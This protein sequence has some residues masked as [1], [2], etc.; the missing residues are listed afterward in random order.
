MR[1]FK[2]KTL[3]RIARSVTNM[4]HPDEVKGYKYQHPSIQRHERTFTDLKGEE[5]I[6]YV[7]GT[8]VRADTE[9]QLYQHMKRDLR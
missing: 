4:K 9:R 1:G 7:T 6:Y 8:I 3:R 2:A 5:H